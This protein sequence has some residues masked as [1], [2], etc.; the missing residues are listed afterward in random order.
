MAGLILR[1]RHSP[2]MTRREATRDA[3]ETGC[4]AVCCVR[5]LSCSLPLQRQLH[6]LCQHGASGKMC[7]LR[8][9]S[10]TSETER[11]SRKAHAITVLLIFNSGG[12][13]SRGEIFA[14][15]VYLCRCGL[16]AELGKAIGKRDSI[17]G[18]DA[19]CRFQVIDYRESQNL[20][21]CHLPPATYFLPLG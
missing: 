11:N 3:S 17:W 12:S 15:V 10:L 16:R 21:P 2:G 1:V 13:K 20:R 18:S 6:A 8:R 14:P 7:S 5:D 9:L 4:E 19:G